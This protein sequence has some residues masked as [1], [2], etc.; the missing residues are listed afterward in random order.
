MS[1]S[2]QPT[3]SLK[4]LSVKFVGS[5][6]EVSQIINADEISSKYHYFLYKHQNPSQYSSSKCIHLAYYIYIYLNFCSIAQLWRLYM[7]SPIGMWK[8]SNKDSLRSTHFWHWLYLTTQAL[9][10]IVVW[11][12]NNVDICIGKQKCSTTKKPCLRL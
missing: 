3:V 4:R 11:V 1:L 6:D 2:P 10:D 7:Y 8:I 9:F 12:V 5:G